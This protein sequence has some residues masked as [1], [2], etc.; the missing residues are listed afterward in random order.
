[1]IFGHIFIIKIT[2]TMENKNEKLTILRHSAAHILASAVLEML[3]EAKFGIGPNIDNG[4][5]Y[6]FDLPRT[7]IPED[8]PLLEEKMRALIAKNLPFEKSEIESSKAKELFQ[9]AG[10]PYKAE[11]IDDLVKAEAV[12]K[13][14]VYR[15]GDFVDLC[16]G[17]HIES[18][19]EIKP[20]AFK[21]L[22]IAGLL[23][24]Q[25]KK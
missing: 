15:T 6:D 22:K 23:E 9:K 10:Q 4:F 24:G 8:L 16:R 14:T 25:R 21:L 1:V 13:V 2:K 12:Q 3:P 11:L 5:Y 20:D 17:P 7:L 18:T 19:K